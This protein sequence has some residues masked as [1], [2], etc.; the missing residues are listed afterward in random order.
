MA[1]PRFLIVC[2]LSLMILGRN[3]LAQTRGRPNPPRPLQARNAVVAQDTARR[4]APL[5]EQELKAIEIKAV[6][7][8][9][10]VA[11]LPKRAEPE[12]GEIEFVDRSFDHEL[13]QG[14]AKPMF[15]DSELES[16]Q[17]LERLKKFLAKEKK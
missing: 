15:I 12:F 5:Q 17:K 4:R 7:E 10:G 1:L 16:A 14:P 2:A 8:K 6:V 11:I 13:K 9:P 3:G